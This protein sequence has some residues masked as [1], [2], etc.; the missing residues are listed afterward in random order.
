MK[1]ESGIYKI[2]CIPNGKIYIGSA[3]RLPKRKNSHFET[4]SKGIHK[5]RHLQNAFIK[6][7]IEKFTFEVIE[8][9]HEKEKLIHCEQIWINK[10]RCY[11]NNTGFNICPIAGST[12]G[13][14][15]SKETK[16][17]RSVLNI[18][19]KFNL[20]KKASHETRKKM[21]N[22]HKGN[23][24]S[25]GRVLSKQTR[26]K[27]SASNKGRISPT[28]GMVYSDES[29]RKMSEKR[30][31]IKLSMETREKMRIAKTGVIMSDETKHKLSKIRTGEKNPFFGRKHSDE[32]KEKFKYR[33]N[34]MT[35]KKHT[36]ET[37]QKIRESKLKSNKVTEFNKI[38][39]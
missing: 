24:Y 14:K 33:K 26:D 31:G 25:V 6:Y 9:V 10:T 11:Y 5:N 2:T 16:E 19:N 22:A 20:G 4:L 39:V 35:G 18:G 23:K 12:L 15:H 28:L 36:E 8:I 27:I 34:G 17:K 3:V 30:M 29:R 1:N 37:K 13:V 21:S 7:G 38:I 32:T